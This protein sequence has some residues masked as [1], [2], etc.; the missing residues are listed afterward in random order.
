MDKAV[1]KL[2]GEYAQNSMTLCGPKKT[3]LGYPIEF[4]KLLNVFLIQKT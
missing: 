2:G 3:V 4:R 1:E